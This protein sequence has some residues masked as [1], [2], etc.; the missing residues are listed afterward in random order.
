MLYYSSP[1]F[2]NYLM[3]VFLQVQAIL[4][5]KTFYFITIKLT[6]RKY[7]SII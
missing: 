5:N 6:Y 4:K 3:N 1:K 2:T 7:M